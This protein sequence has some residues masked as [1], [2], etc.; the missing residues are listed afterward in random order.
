MIIDVPTFLIVTVSAIVESINPCAIGVLILLI[1]I[2]LGSKSSP[3]RLVFLGGLYIAA[4][5]VTYL[6]AGLGL[7]Y[8]LARVPL[9]AAEYAA[10]LVGIL[11]IVA[12]LFEI[13]DFFWYGEGVSLQTPERF[14]RKITT[15]VKNMTIPGVI[16][17]GVFIAAVEL[18]CTGAPYLAIITLLSLHFDAQAFVLLVYYNVLFVTPLIV[19]LL[20]V[21]GGTQVSIIKKWKQSNRHYMRFAIGFLL[22]G[23]GWLLILIANGTI[24]LG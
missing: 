11:V 7:T 21:A 19:I 20:L 13:K 9:V 1:S 6:L 4:I 16:F 10:L 2:L 15:Y 14:A 18:P 12:G 17:L 8:F 22:I 5:C 3:V 23:L 24:N